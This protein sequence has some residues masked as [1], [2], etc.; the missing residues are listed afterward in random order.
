MTTGP[1]TGLT[2]EQALIDCAERW[3]HA[4]Q[5]GT[6][7]ALPT[8]EAVLDLIKRKF[9]AGYQEFLSAHNWSFLDQQVTVLAYP[10][11][12]GPDNID[13]DPARYRLPN[14]IRGMPLYDWEFVGDAR[15][16][17]TVAN[18]AID[19]VRKRAALYTRRTGIP[20]W[21]GCGPLNENGPPEQGG[22]G[23]EVMFWPAPALTYEMRTTFRIEQHEL[24]ENNERHIAGKAHDRTVIAFANWEWYRDDAEDPDLRERYRLELYGNPATGEKGAL[25]RSIDIDGQHRNRRRGS[26][27][28]ERLRHA[29]RRKTHRYLGRVQYDGSYLDASQ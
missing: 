27:S 5:S 13:S 1:F 7:P 23:W 6:V 11:G 15:P 4:G 10:N 20:T 16:R 17:T 3:G 19:I 28:T 8:D 26:I 2:F 25:Q 22:N 9:N 21:A 29:N 18:I 24:V 12:D 14:N